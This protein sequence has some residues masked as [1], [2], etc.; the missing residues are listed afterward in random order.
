MKP[1]ENNFLTKNEGLFIWADL[2]RQVVNIKIQSKDHWVIH[3]C[4]RK[5]ASYYIQQLQLAVNILKEGPH[6]PTL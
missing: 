6:Q 5:S 4:D 2:R 1:I 3:S